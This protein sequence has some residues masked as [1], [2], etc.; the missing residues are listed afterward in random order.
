M[1]F[2]FLIHPLYHRV[3]NIL[4]GVEIRQV[5]IDNS[6]VLFKLRRDDRNGGNDNCCLIGGF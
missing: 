3:K 4:H 5:E 6:N 1:D 2:T